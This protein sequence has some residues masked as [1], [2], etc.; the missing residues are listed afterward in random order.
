MNDFP[1]HSMSREQKAV[2]RARKAFLTGRSKALEYRITQLKNLLRFVKERQKEIAE[3]LK[4]DL[5]RVGV[6]FTC[7]LSHSKPCL[8]RHI[9]NGLCFIYLVTE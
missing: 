6:L 5:K 4:K 2:E 9:A 8:L 3:G 1:F 7:V